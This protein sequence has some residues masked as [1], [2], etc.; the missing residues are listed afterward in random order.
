MSTAEWLATTALVGFV[1]LAIA[2]WRTSR[3]LHTV[4]R[5]VARLRDAV[6]RD[7]TPAVEEARRDADAAVSEA[8]RAARAAG[9]PEPPPRLA[10]ETVTGPVV[11][12]VAIGAGARR[13]LRRLTGDVAAGPRA[14]G[15]VTTGARSHVRTP[16]GTKR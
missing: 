8:R 5:E 12:M 15:R 14:G 1:V 13:A 16:S 2:W 4:S 7:L 11:R 3:R 6:R 9:I 10:L